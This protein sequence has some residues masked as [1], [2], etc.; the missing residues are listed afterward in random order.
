[1]Q[2]LRRLPLA[3][4]LALP[5]ARL[6]PQELMELDGIQLRGS[7]RL[8]A[9]GAA[10]CEI[11]EGFAGDDKAYDPANRGLPLDLWQLEFSV[12]NGSGK[13][14]DHL[15][16]RYNIESEW[17]PC[18]S[19]DGPP[20]GTVE[21]AVL[22]AGHHGFIQKTGRNVVA[23]DDR[24]TET[25]YLVVFS[26]DPAPYFEHWSMNYQFAR[27]PPTEGIGGR[28]KVLPQERL[29][30]TTAAPPGPTCKG[31][32]ASK[33]WMEV[34][35]RS[36]CYVW[37]QTRQRL[38]NWLREATW[39][40][41]CPTG[42]ADG[43][44]TI[45]SSHSVEEGLYKEGKK[46]GLWTETRR[47]GTKY[48]ETY[49]AGMLH[50]PMSVRHSTGAVDEYLWQNGKMRESPS[51]PTENPA[52][53]STNQTVRGQEAARVENPGSCSRRRLIELGTVR[54]ST[55]NA[56]IEFTNSRMTMVNRSVAGPD[57]SVTNEAEYSVSSGSITYTIVRAHGKMGAINE[58]LPITN[59]GPHTV[60][61]RLERNTLH[62]GNR[63]W[64]R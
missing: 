5:A 38:I 17:P 8:V 27:F 33:C 42:V 23:P 19:W 50:G 41:S 59:P 22:W 47:D 31:E 39:S 28:E 57:A 36:G 40:G 29:P 26:T 10:T 13:W 34:P 58:T 48:S 14:L 63:T 54:S 45:R 43:P 49:R 51:T 32:R 60:D 6:Q 62:F 16:A 56:T 35:N 64:F 61:C 11:R 12:Y 21:G 2:L 18:S 1:M 52:A 3:V 44:W 46:H 55:G 20:A 37:Q 30:S 7:A 4:L 53:S 25:I 24:F 9:R 15:I